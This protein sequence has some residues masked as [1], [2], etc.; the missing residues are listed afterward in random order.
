MS[1]HTK[2]Q[3]LQFSRS[4]LK[5]FGGGGYVTQN[6]KVSWLLSQYIAGGYVCITHPYT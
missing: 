4:G 3:F 5:V 6:L 2:F 1:F